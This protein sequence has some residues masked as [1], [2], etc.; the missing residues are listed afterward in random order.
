MSKKVSITL[1][2]HV[3]SLALK[4]SRLTHGENNFSAYLRE[5]I[6]K[7]F[8]ADDLKTE[9]IKLNEPLWLGITKTSDY[10][11][12]CMVCNNPISPGDTICYTNLGFQEVYKNWV[13]K[14]CCRKE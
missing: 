2:D 4:K 10:S 11:S 1:P 5:L 7:E 8:T 12:T 13:H 14:N 9:L 6:S 3:Y